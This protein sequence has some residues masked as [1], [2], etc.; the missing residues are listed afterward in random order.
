MSNLGL[1]VVCLGI[2]LVVGLWTQHRVK[3]TFAAVVAGA[4]GHAA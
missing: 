3:S 4:R 2:P 1:Y